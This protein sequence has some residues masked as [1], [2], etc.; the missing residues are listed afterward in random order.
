MNC[1]EGAALTKEIFKELRD[2]L[3]DVGFPIFVAVYT[4]IRLET[5]IARNTEAI[6]LLRETLKVALQSTGK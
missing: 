1:R 6:Q 5:A 4:L 3:R 2:F